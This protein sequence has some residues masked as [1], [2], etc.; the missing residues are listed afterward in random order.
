MTDRLMISRSWAIGVIGIALT[1]AGSLS[2]QE[3]PDPLQLDRQE[4]PER[5]LDAEDLAL[6]EDAPRDADDEE[7]ITAQIQRELLE[8]VQEFLQEREGSRDRARRDRPRR[9]DRPSRRPLDRPRRAR[10]RA[11]GDV[12]VDRPEE[13]RFFHL[14]QA[15]DHLRALGWN[16][17]ADRLR[18]RWGA[19]G[20][21]LPR[22]SVNSEFRVSWAK[23]E[24]GPCDA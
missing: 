3:S 10:D 23:I 24:W 12:E 22:A 9:V 7:G 14:V 11:Q 1:M 21:R 5:D 15:V 8:R 19:E 13:D 4:D 17:E 18:R 6:Q 2:A 16:D 20:R